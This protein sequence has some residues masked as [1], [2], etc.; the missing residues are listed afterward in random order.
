MDIVRVVKDNQSLS[1]MCHSTVCRI[2]DQDAI[3][4]WRFHCWIFPRDPHFIE[5]AGVVIDIYQRIWHGETLGERDFV[6][7]TDEK[8]SIQARSR[9]HPSKPLASEQ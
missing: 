2:L 9:K 8:T 6:I 3:R 5:K 7:S 4:P 1:H